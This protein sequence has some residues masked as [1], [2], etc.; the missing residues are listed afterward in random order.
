M[1]S[2]P[3]KAGSPKDLDSMFNKKTSGNRAKSLREHKTSTTERS[4]ENAKHFQDAKN[5]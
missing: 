2:S 4:H 3:A 5:L 1:L